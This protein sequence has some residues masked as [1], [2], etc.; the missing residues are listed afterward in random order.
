MV[1]I[2]PIIMVMLGMVYDVGF[3]TLI[4]F[5][6]DNN[7]LFVCLVCLVCLVD[8]DIPRLNWF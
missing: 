6:H 3:T 8:C 4:R 7:D 2:A 1:Y 5:N